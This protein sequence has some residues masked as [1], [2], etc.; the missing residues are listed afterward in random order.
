M[1]LSKL[2]TISFI[3]FF[4]F[5]TLSIFFMSAIAGKWDFLFIY[6]FQKIFL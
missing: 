3:P 4:D 2:R 5:D 6:S 1:Y